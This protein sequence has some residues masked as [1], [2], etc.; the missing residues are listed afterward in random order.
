MS[1]EVARLR[2]PTMSALAAAFGGK[3]DSLCSL[4]VLPVVTPERSLDGL[5]S[6]SAAVPRCSWGVLSFR[7]EAR[8]HRAVKRR[9]FITLLGS[10]ATANCEDNDSFLSVAIRCL[11]HALA[12]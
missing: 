1:P 8:R 10:A 2:H 9:A 11:S 3:A 12:P 6:R 4:R 5:K 7:S